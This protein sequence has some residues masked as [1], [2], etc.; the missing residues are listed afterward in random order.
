MNKYEQL[1]LYG[2]IAVMYIGYSVETWWQPLCFLGGGFLLILSHCF[3]NE[4]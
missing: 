2:G 3:T 1:F 4:K